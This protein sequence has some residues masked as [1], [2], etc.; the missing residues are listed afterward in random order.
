[1]CE[2]QKYLVTLAIIWGIF[3]LLGIISIAVPVAIY[4]IRIDEMALQ[5]GYSQ[6]EHGKWKK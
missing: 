3:I 4:N 2:Q 5:N 6:D 1:M